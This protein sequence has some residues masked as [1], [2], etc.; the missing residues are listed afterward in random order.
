MHF[1]NACFSAHVGHMTIFKP[2]G[3]KIKRQTSKKFEN[4]KG[5]SLLSIASPE[6]WD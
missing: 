4:F 5:V 1:E 3:S 2:K 6:F